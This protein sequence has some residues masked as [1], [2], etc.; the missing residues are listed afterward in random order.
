MTTPPGRPVDVLY[1][2]LAHSSP[3]TRTHRPS[4][5]RSRPRRA[6]LGDFGVHPGLRLQVMSSNLEGRIT[7]AID[8]E[9]YTGNK[10]RLVRTK[11]SNGGCHFARLPEA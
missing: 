8:G 1:Q 5:Q 10:G 11:P 7:A 6:G 9:R 2:L 4:R 3:V